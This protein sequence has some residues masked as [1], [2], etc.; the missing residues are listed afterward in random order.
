MS[1]HGVA[2]WRHRMSSRVTVSSLDRTGRRRSLGSWSV[3]AIDRATAN[4]VADQLA[5]CLTSRCFGQVLCDRP[6]PVWFNEE[7][8]TRLEIRCG[9]PRRAHSFSVDFLANERELT[10]KIFR[11]PLTSPNPNMN[12]KLIFPWSSP[13]ITI[14][15]ALC[16]LE[17]LL[18]RRL[19]RSYWCRAG[20]STNGCDTFEPPVVQTEANKGNPQSVPADWSIPWGRTCTLVLTWRGDRRGMM[21]DTST[22]QALQGYD[23]LWESIVEKS[24]NCTP[25]WIRDKMHQR[26]EKGVLKFDI[27]GWFGRIYKQ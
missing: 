12:V 14:S 17:L 3:N 7:T 26:E 10:G 8:V 22:A 1:E 6:R 18:R 13:S 5:T 16:V 9:R 19:G 15:L 2:W 23:R 11:T 21:R 25:S 24:S 20:L 27:A 4:K